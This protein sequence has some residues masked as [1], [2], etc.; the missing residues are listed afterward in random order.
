MSNEFI[1]DYENDFYPPKKEPEIQI[2]DFITGENTIPTEDQE[3]VEAMLNN[4]PNNNTNEEKRYLNGLEEV[5]K[6]YKEDEWKR[7]LYSAPSDLMTQELQRRLSAAEQYRRA[8]IEA[9]EVMKQL[10]L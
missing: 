7:L 9:D 10:K 2:L 6:N 5:G 1:D 3:K 8:M 4:V